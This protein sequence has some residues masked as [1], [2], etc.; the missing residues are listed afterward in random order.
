MELT[1]EQIEKFK[2][3]HDKYGGLGEY[4]ETEIKNIA[5]GVAGY[6]LELFKIYKEKR[7]LM[8]PFD[9]GDFQQKDYDITRTITSTIITI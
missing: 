6:H 8:E 7:E 3:I 1:P 4:S 5:N 9:L 2:R